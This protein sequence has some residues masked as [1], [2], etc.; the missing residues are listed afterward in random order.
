MAESRKDLTDAL[1]GIPDLQGSGNLPRRVSFA[2][3]LGVAR[4]YFAF[5]EGI[6]DLSHD[7]WR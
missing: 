4:Q 3:Q 2:I 1:M 6:L 7:S 5:H